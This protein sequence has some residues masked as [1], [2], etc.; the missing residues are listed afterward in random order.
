MVYL[1]RNQWI[2]AIVQLLVLV[3]SI[4]GAQAGKK[5]LPISQ[6]LAA[7]TNPILEN[8]ARIRLANNRALY[9]R[10][11]LTKRLQNVCSGKRMQSFA[12]WFRRN[13]LAVVS[14]HGRDD[15]SM[16]D[17]LV[18]IETIEEPFLRLRRWRKDPFP[19]DRRSLEMVSTR[20]SPE[21]CHT[22]ETPVNSSVLRNPTNLQLCLRALRLGYNFAP[23]ISTVGIAVF[24]TQ[25]RRKRWYPWLS[26]CI[27]SSGPA[28]IKWGQWSSTR[29]DMFPEALCDV[30]SQLHS[31]APAHSW[32]FSKQSIE[33]S[34]G[35]ATDTLFNVFDDFDEQP[36]ASGSIAQ[37]HSAV[38]DGT[39][40]AVKVRHPDVARLLDMDFRIMSA[41]ARLVDW[42]PGLRWLHVQE[43]VDQ[44]SHTMAAQS[45][46]Q[47]EAHHLEVLYHNFRS[48]NTVRFPQPIY[49]SPSCIIETFE[50]GRI[51]SSLLDRYDGMADYVNLGSYQGYVQVTE[52]D[53]TE[54]DYLEGNDLIPTDMARFIVTMGLA[55]YLKMLLV[56][57][58]MHAD[59]HPGNIM[60]DFP[61]KNH[62]TISLVDAGMV[63]QLTDSESSTFIG[64]LS[65]LGEG[66]GRDA[67]HFALQFSV[68]SN[69][70]DK[71]KEAFS[72]DMEDLFD[73]RCRGYGT[74]VNV[75]H[76]LRG[77]LNL[78]RKH[79]VRIDANFA[80]LVINALCLES[81][82]NEVCPTYNLL[83]FSKPLLRSYRRICYKSDGTP[84][85]A[86]RR[87]RWLKFWLAIKYG[88]KERAEARFFKRRK[89]MRKSHE[90]VY[91]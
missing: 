30:L 19:E 75:G 16:D 46:L 57:N 27:G 81:M 35:L 25:F 28:W 61:R 58:L 20:A 63:A 72:Q 52:P 8:E 39:R 69:M 90:F 59:L 18:A 62:L 55:I 2:W 83:D 80:T 11:V 32:E 89:R 15:E 82:A 73:E 74:N 77:V 64:L 34:L 86:A 36:L 78:I 70:S 84:K 33:E 23:V 87:S 56:D 79:R 43:S 7:P 65:S 51:V 14:S 24:S 49:A 10:A 45:Q 67:A 88:V 50:N 60:L 21:A 12:A 5:S 66:N 31:D 54:E 37:I 42:I 53:G 4:P 6:C 38:L 9:I 17:Q 76:V 40:V 44:F 71:A 29:S 13:E 1:R 48:W 22:S 3:K 47:V 68:D 85:P 26:K 91:E 41:A